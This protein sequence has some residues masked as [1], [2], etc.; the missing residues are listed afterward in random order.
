MRIVLVHDFHHSDVP[1][2]EDAVVRAEA[3][4]LARAGMRVDVVGCANDEQAQRP[5]HSARAAITV[6]T[7]LGRSPLKG[8]ADVV[9]VHNLFPYLPTR[10]I[11]R[12]DSPIVTTLHSYRPVCANGFLFRDGQVCTAC[13]D[14]DPWAGV[15]HG[16]YRSSR[17]ATLPVSIGGRRGA[18]LDPLL[19]G[20]AR[21][22]VLSERSLEVMTAAGVDP[23][24][25]TLDRHFLPDDLVP[26]RGP[27]GATWLVVGRLGPEKGI[28]PLVRR[29]P[30]DLPLRIVGD[31][32]ER[33]AITKAAA[34]KRIELVGSRPRHE[35]TAMLAEARGLV[36][37]S[38][39]FET[40]GLVYMEALSAGTP[41]LAF[42]PNVVA[43][44]VRRDRTGAVGSLAT[45]DA[46]LATAELRFP[47]LR[48]HCRS[49]FEVRFTERD[50]IE[51]RTALYS[52]LANA[53]R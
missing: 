41:T 44:A 46:D 38:L 29:W 50:F 45:L 39:W 14:G 30:G 33:A 19:S 28:E 48:A 21:I 6:A 32:P 23:A 36:V 9:H 20:S 22:L 37:P 25:M 35:V 7:G 10:W 24:R 27:G 43:D 34:G 26:E 11:S 12:V 31:G 53:A 17:L 49:V 42:E 51:R 52:S 8:P 1:S 15:R 4:A 3:A 13:P 2:G 47:D 16:C 18:A 40:F 5:L